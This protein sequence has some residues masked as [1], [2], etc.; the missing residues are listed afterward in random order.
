M[1]K[2]VD[3]EQKSVYSMEVQASNNVNDDQVIRYR[4]STNPSIVTVTV[5]VQ[6]TNDTPPKFLQQTYSACELGVKKI[7]LIVFHCR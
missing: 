2:T 3:R 6:D 5:Q 7:I 4:R 1:A